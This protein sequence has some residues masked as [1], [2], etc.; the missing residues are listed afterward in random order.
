MKKE[1]IKFRYYKSDYS[2]FPA[3]IEN[4]FIG[5]A[6]VIT[7]EDGEQVEIVELFINGLRPDKIWGVT[8]DWTLFLDEMREAARRCSDEDSQGRIVMPAESVWHKLHPEPTRHNLSAITAEQG[9]GLSVA[10]VDAMAQYDII[11][12]EIINA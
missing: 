10:V 12:Y 9:E 6:E 5:V 4:E 8:K 7:D 3:G 2:F 1:H 11:T